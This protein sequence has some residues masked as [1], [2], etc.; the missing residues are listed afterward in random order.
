MYTNIY[1]CAELYSY[2]LHCIDL[3]TKFE[4]TGPWVLVQQHI[5]HN[6][7][8]TN[9]LKTEW[10]EKNWSGLHGKHVYPYQIHGDMGSTSFC[11]TQ[12]CPHELHVTWCIYPSSRVDG[13]DDS[14]STALTHLLFL[15]MGW[16]FK[17][18][19]LAILRIQQ[20]FYLSC[21]MP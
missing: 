2:K 10:R 3:P 21:G 1:R 9:K 4:T 12:S 17:V 8:G 11:I 18:V 19:Q 20:M 14:C 7:E 15:N 5:C 13:T 6:N 16:N